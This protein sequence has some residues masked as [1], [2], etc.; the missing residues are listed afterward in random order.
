MSKCVGWGA[1]CE[2]KSTLEALHLPWRSELVAVEG[3]TREVLKGSGHGE[4]GYKLTCE[5]FGAY[6]PEE[7]TGSPVLTTTNGASGVTA[8]FLAS[9]KVKCEAVSKAI[10]T[11]TLEDTQTIEA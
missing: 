8:T 11:G 9:E 7:C 4:P 1:S 10:Y 6:I 3:T 2:S 5:V